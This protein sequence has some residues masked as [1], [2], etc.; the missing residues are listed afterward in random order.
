MSLTHQ[1]TLTNYSQSPLILATVPCIAKIRGAIGWWSCSVGVDWTDGS[2]EDTILIRQIDTREDLQQTHMLNFTL[3]E[4]RIDNSCI[5]VI[6]AEKYQLIETRQLKLWLHEK[7]GEIWIIFIHRTFVSRFVDFTAQRYSHP[8]N[9]NEYDQTG[10]LKI[11]YTN[12]NKAVTQSQTRSNNSN[13]I[14]TIT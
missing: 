13:I 4:N 11:M 3:Q 12:T 7:W 8:V 10:N 1:E 14:L 5:P 6:I 2:N 9:I